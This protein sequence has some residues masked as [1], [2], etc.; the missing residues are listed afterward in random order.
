MRGKKRVVRPGYGIFALSALPI[1]HVLR[2]RICA[3]D[4]RSSY[5]PANCSLTNV[6][7][8]PKESRGSMLKRTF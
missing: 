3:P 8:A 6:K 7:R 4:N 1:L 5:F 2:A